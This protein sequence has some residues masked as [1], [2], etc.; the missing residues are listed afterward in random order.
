MKKRIYKKKFKKY[1]V[2]YCK[3]YNQDLYTKKDEI[4]FNTLASN[5]YLAQEENID[6]DGE[7]NYE[8]PELDAEEC[9]S[10]W[11]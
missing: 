1:I 2:D 7:E 6:F 10:Y 9:I 3:S 5:E 4:W 8:Y 11:E